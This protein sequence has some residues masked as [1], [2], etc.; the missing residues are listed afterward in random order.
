MERGK[1]QA[2]ADTAARA[3]ADLAQKGARVVE[4]TADKAVNALH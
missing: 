2:A 1:L 3:G 4:Q